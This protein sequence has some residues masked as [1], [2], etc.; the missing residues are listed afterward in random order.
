MAS[1]S[2]STQ[3]PVY[4][5]SS[6]P[7]T[8]PLILCSSHQAFSLLPTQATV[9]PHLSLSFLC[10]D[11]SES[12]QGSLFLSFKTLKGFF[13]HTIKNT[14]HY[15]KSTQS[16]CPLQFLHSINYYLKTNFK[17]ICLLTC[18]LSPALEYNPQEHRHHVYLS[19]YI[20][21]T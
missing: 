12:F 4:L 15:L 5:I 17:L 7:L 11:P 16:P 13:E 14:L 1:K 6:T 2:Q 18:Y 8:R 21:R 19:P 3:A 10:L 9:V 20:P